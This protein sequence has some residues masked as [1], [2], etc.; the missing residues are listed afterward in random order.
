[1]DHEILPIATIK[2]EG[3]AAAI[4]RAC[5]HEANPYLFDSGHWRIWNGA[6]LA[7]RMALGRR[8]STSD[9]SAPCRALPGCVCARDREAK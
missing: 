5:P 8:I 6:F 4:E 9:E 2:A 1:M 3:R 7:A